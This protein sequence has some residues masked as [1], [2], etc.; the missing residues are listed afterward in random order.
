[1][2]NASRDG[3]IRGEQRIAHR[4]EIN[5]TTLYGSVEIEKLNCETFA[6]SLFALNVNKI[7]V[8]LLFY[9]GA[10]ASELVQVNSLCEF[11]GVF[12]CNSFIFNLSTK[13]TTTTAR[14]YL[15]V[16]TL[17]FVDSMQREWKL[18]RISTGKRMVFLEVLLQCAT[19]ENKDEISILSHFFSLRFAT[20]SSLA[21]S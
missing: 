4:K 11:L 16:P 15:P 20:I 3:S 5:S 6:I 10:V 13:T 7:A 8:C 14:T 21:T 1:M 18:N 9:S 19:N 2:S 12:R 17:G